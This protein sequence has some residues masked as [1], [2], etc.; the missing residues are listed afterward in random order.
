MRRDARPRAP[1]RRISGEFRYR[2]VLIKSSISNFKYTVNF[3]RTVLSDVCAPRGFHVRITRFFV[4]QS[5]T[6]NIR[7]PDRQC[8]KRHPHTHSLLIEARPATQY[9]HLMF[10][11]IAHPHLRL[12]ERGERREG[13]QAVDERLRRG[14]IVA[15]DGVERIDACNG[16]KMRSHTASRE[17]GGCRLPVA[18]GG[19]ALY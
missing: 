6:Q 16:K 14:A 5:S 9:T 4:V 19:L 11:C 17:R 1:N 2:F 12:S 3:S 8:A 13:V 7:Q 10:A 15:A 18:S